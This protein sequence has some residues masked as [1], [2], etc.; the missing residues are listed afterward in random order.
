MKSFSLTQMD[1]K[2]TLAYAL[3]QDTE[4]PLKKYRA[5][6][7]FPRLNEREVVYFSGNTLGL[8]PKSTQDHILN[9][10]EDW[11]SFGVQA[12]FHAR[13]PW[14]TYP[15]QF[16]KPI[17]KIAGAKPSEVAVMNQLTVNLHL[18][19]VSFYRPDKKKYKI[20]C[21]SGAFSSDQYAMETQTLFHG[22]QPE[23]AIIEL[24]PRAGEHCL[25]MEDILEAIEK[26]KDSL[27]LVLIGGVNYLTGQLFN[28]KQITAA[29]HKAGAL[30]GFDLAHAI[31]NVKLELHDWDV[32]FAVWCSYKYLNSGPGGIAGIFIHERHASNTNL[33]R[34]AGRWGADN[35]GIGATMK[36]GFVPTPTA[37][38]W[39]LSNF[40]IVLMAAHKAALDQFDEA[41][42]DALVLKSLKLTAYL[43]FIID[44]INPDLEQPFEIITPRNHHER[45]CQLSIL[46]GNRGEEL[47]TK[48][49]QAGIIA[50]WL[51]PNILRCA[52]VPFYNSFE[53]VYRFGDVLRRIS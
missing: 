31:G 18:L 21:E 39:Q 23:D 13:I 9:E 19:M 17:S 43:E 36:K 22:F 29:A 50:D 41:G 24:S 52:P 16:A 46:T 53:D 15:E 28:M 42:M 27:A 4:D 12:R 49:L 10:L 14:L 40:P 25:R 51:E 47:N 33:L 44:I 35:K 8:Q 6:F 5:Q 1:F 11:A 34:F 26:N 2:N 32:D 48:L 20:L 30:A 3:Q 37:E 7:Y 38:G 45:G